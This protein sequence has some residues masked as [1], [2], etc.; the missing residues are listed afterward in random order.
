MECGFDWDAGADATIAAIAGFPE[1]YEKCLT[2]FLA[3]EDADQLL[4]ARPAPGVW[5][6]VE[7]AAHLRD[8]IDFYRDRIERVL[9]ES[10]PQMHSVGFAR[11][12]E[13]RGYATEEIGPV[14]AA[15]GDG[16]REVAG[17]LRALDRDEWDRV[18]IGSDGDERSVLVL[19]RRLAHDGHHHLLDI[20]RGL[21]RLRE[22]PPA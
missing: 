6:A 3:G 11:L 20:G 13:E 5:S 12:A 14:L 8:V 4:R 10:R 9:T 1:A 16:A 17:R 21:R 22:S 7:Y 19:S 18:G 2:R 15:I